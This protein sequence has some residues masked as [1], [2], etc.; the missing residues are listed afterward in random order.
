MKISNSNH[1]NACLLTVFRGFSIQFV[2]IDFAFVLV[3]LF[4]DVINEE[5]L[6]DSFNKLFVF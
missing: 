3:V 5:G 4:A 2:Y 6:H 1:V